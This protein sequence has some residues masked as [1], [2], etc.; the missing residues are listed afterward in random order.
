MYTMTYAAIMMTVTVTTTMHSPRMP[1]AT[2]IRP[3]R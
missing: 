2:R 1:Y 3:K